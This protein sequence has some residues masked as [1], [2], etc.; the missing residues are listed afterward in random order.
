MYNI[1][2]A[3]VY[4]SNGVCVITAIENRD[5]SGENVEYYILQPVNNS[6]ILSMY[7]LQ[8]LHSEI[9]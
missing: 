7:R 6:K 2:D 9:K 8:I 4:G 1:N 5:F 3:V